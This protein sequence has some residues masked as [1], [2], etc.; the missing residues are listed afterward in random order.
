[1]DFT[2]NDDQLM[3]RDSV[4]AFLTNE[5]TPEHIRSLWDTDSGRSPEF[6]PKLAEL[7]LTAMTVPE[8]Y[9]GLGMNALD[10]VLL[11]QECGY[12]A[13]P[14]VLV[15]T[16]LVAIPLIAELDDAHEGFKQD[17]L[18]QIAEGSA[19]VAVAHPDNLLVADAHMADLLLLAHNGEVHGVPAVDVTLEANPS[20]DPSRRLFSVQWTPSDATKLAD[21]ET[22]ALLWQNAFNR[23]A[24]GVAAQQLGLA[25]RMMDVTVDYTY[26]RKQF[27]KPVGSFQA[28]KHMMADV[29]VKVEF[30]RPPLIK[31]A[32]DIANGEASAALA[33]SH[34]KLVASEAVR[35]AAKNGIQ[36]HG[37]MGYT[38]EVDLQIFMKAGWAMDASYGDQGTHKV[39]IK[40]AILA[41]GAALG[42]G[43]SF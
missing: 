42:A 14:G 36:A 22:G 18:P 37:A 34:A 9:G 30:A 2:F 38:W 17:W 24:L 31:A 7:G 33:V 41:E 11:A 19:R 25:K 1:M 3:F 29:A 27:G 20:V 40:S 32:Y 21:A 39:R 13:M 5:M 10:F 43:A 23:G 16:A 28:V 26:E 35:A 15:E 12:A 4:K 6:W 8:Q